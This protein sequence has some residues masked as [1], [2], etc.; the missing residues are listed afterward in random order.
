MSS[1]DLVP[2]RITVNSP[3]FQQS[4][5]DKMVGEASER[6]TP[7]FN[8]RLCNQQTHPGEEARQAEEIF[9]SPPLLY[10]ELDSPAKSTTTRARGDRS[11]IYQLWATYCKF[12]GAR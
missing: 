10:Q 1:L 8:R 5:K 6:A 9:T 12:V 4:H 11:I 2:P 7:E 3:T